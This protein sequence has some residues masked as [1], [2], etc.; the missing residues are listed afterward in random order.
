MHASCQM[1]TRSIISYWDIYYYICTYI[2]S[3]KLSVIRANN[4]NKV[5]CP[6]IFLL[7]SLISVFIFWNYESDSI[8]QNTWGFLKLSHIHYYH[9][10]KKQNIIKQSHKELILV[11]HWDWMIGRDNDQLNC[12]HTTLP[13]PHWLL[14]CNLHITQVR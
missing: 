8:R 14:A 7:P 10:K 2:V 1:E 5:V 3:W 6:H 12:L 9:W 11:R 13:H 4:Q